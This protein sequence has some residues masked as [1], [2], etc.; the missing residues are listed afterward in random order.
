MP[1]KIPKLKVNHDVVKKFRP[2]NE[3]VQNG[4]SVIKL[5]D[6]PIESR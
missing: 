3:Q 2:E 6:Q 5:T 1:H 4:L